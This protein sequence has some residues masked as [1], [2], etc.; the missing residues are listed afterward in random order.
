M[1]DTDTSIPTKVKWLDRT[2]GWNHQRTY[3]EALHA[4]VEVGPMFWP[5]AAMYVA[6]VMR[7]NSTGRLWSQPTFG[8]LVA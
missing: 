4:A 3:E 1:H 2:Y 6:D 7:H 5:Y 8:E